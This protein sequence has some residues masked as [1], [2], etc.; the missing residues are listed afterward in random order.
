[1]VSHSSFQMYLIQGYYSELI[2][3]LLAAIS[4]WFPKFK[5]RYINHASILSISEGYSRL[6]TIFSIVSEFQCFDWHKIDI[7]FAFCQGNAQFFIKNY[8]C[9]AFNFAWTNSLI[10]NPLHPSFQKPLWNK[11]F[12]ELIPRIF[13]SLD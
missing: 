2:Y 12:F 6:L 9:K 4:R 8:L 1:M 5:E 11:S 13:K 10:F 7:W 3:L